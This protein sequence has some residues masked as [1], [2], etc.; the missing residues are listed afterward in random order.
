MPARTAPAPADAIHTADDTLDADVE[1]AE[2]VVAIKTQSE[3]APAPEIVV[4][5]EAGDECAICL[6]E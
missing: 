3:N 5:E 2:T 4:V 6:S 1:A